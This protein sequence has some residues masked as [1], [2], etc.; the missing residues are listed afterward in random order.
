[1]RQP[2]QEMAA[3][4]VKIGYQKPDITFIEETDDFPT[5]SSLNMLCKMLSSCHRVPEKKYS[6]YF[7]CRILVKNYSLSD[8]SHEQVSCH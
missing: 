1:M 5:L 7:L 6:L 2:L 4:L 8:S 3:S